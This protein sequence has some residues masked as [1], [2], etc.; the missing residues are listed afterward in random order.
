MVTNVCICRYSDKNIAK[1]AS[2]VGLT[3]DR[4]MSGHGV[5]FNIANFGGYNLQKGEF[6]LIYNTNSKDI[7]IYKS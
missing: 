4:M 7:S 6:Y 5:G 1:K 2:K 3:E